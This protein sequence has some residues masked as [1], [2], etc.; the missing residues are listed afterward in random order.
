MQS[1]FYDQNNR[2]GRDSFVPQIAV[3]D[4]LFQDLPCLPYA[5]S[6]TVREAIRKP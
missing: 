1:H 5:I 3:I 4:A 2:L 6:M